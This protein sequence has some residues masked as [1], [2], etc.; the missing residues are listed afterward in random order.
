MR[1]LFRENSNALRSGSVVIACFAASTLLTGCLNLKGII[2]PNNTDADVLRVKAAKLTRLE[3]KI[4]EFGTKEHKIKMMPLPHFMF[5]QVDAPFGK[6]FSF[7]GPRR[8]DGRSP[9]VAINILVKKEG[10]PDLKPWAMMELLLKP[11]V[12][13]CLDYLS[14]TKE[15]FTAKGR[16]YHATEFTGNYGGFYQIKGLA[17]VTPIEGGYVT[18]LVQDKASL[19][20]ETVAEFKQWFETFQIEY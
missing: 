13:N 19:F 18:L 14:E 16:T 7:T 17:Y 1:P 8:K 12:G 9:V 4:H 2:K 3:N 5:S 10:D 15:P 6:V 11:F 20:S